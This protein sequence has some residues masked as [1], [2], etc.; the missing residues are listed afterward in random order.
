VVETHWTGLVDSAKRAV[1]LGHSWGT[2]MNGR[3]ATLL[4]F[5]SA[6]ASLNLS[7]IGWGH[8]LEAGSQGVHTTERASVRVSQLFD[9]TATLISMTRQNPLDNVWSS[10][11]EIANRG[12]LGTIAVDRSGN[13]H[14]VYADH[15]WD[16]DNNH[17]SY[18]M[19]TSEI[20]GTETIVSAY[21]YHDGSGF[22]WYGDS[23]DTP[24]IAVDHSGR[25]HVA[26]R[27]DNHDSGVDRSIR[28]VYAKVSW[29][30]YLPAVVKQ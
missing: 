15:T 1:R 30:V 25:L 6:T 2:A 21:E 19:H 10:P 22:P 17:Y 26:Y 14:V 3:S 8:L 13:W 24:S 28:Y 18:I 5:L 11:Q 7:L 12:W 16:V 9:A 4:A 29:K 27:Y 23:V 20:S